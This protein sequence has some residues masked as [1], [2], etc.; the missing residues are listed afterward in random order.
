[1]GRTDEVIGKDAQGND[2]HRLVF[3]SVKSPGNSP[4]VITVGATDAHGTAKR[5]DDTVTEWSSKGPTQFDHLAKPDLVAP[6]RRVVAAMSQEPTPEL[7]LE[8]PDRIVQPAGGNAQR[9]AYYTYSGTSFSA[10]VVAGTVALMLEANKSLTPALV[11][12]TLTKTANALPDSLFASK[13]ASVLTQ[14]V[15]QVNAAAAVELARAFVPN[16]DKLKA[17]QE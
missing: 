10:P 11:K 8:A 17:G 2:I 14:G 9:N 15:G 4:Y 7:A 6:G 3:G 16:A 1:N 12:A 5:S 13:A